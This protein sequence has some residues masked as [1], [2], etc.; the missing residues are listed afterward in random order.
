MGQSYVCVCGGGCGNALGFTNP[1]LLVSVTP[2]IEVL[3]STPRRTLLVIARHYL[4]TTG[5]AVERLSIKCGMAG[6]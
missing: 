2:L 3:G 6:R 1:S 4:L 5:F